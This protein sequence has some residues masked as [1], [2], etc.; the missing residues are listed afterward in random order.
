[1]RRKTS[2]WRIAAAGGAPALVGELGRI[3]A[4]SIDVSRDG[5]RVFFGAGSGV[6]VEVWALENVL[7]RST[8]TR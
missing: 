3:P 1:V 8:A 5:R 7:P 6:T 2:L 4:A